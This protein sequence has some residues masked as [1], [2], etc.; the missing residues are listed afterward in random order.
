VPKPRK[1]DRPIEKSVN[2]PQSLATQVDLLLYSEL[3]GRVPHGAWSRY[4]ERLIR[5]NLTGKPATSGDK[6]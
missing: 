2:I 1:V 3:E 6:S 4:I 5:E